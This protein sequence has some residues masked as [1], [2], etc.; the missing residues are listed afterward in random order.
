MQQGNKKETEGTHKQTHS[1][2][3]RYDNSK[4]D[5]QPEGGGGMGGA[6]VKRVDVNLQRPRS[7]SST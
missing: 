7:L 4:G 5:P 3:W 1:F 6:F 2:P